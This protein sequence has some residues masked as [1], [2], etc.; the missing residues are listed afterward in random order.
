MRN[1]FSNYFL[2]KFYVFAF[3][4]KYGYW[5]LIPKAIIRYVY[6]KIVLREYQ[7]HSWHAIPIE[8]RPYG[9]HVVEYFK[10]I[11]KTDDVA[12]EVGVGIGEIINRLPACKKYGFDLEEKVILAANKVNDSKDITYQ[13]GSFNQ[14]LN[15][16]EKKLTA[17]FCLQFL[18][19]IPSQEL[20]PIFQKLINEKEIKYIV[21]DI[22]TTENEFIHD[23]EKIFGDK[24]SL[25]EEKEFIHPISEGPIINLIFKKND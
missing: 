2:G 8:L 15:I 11:L 19:S 5:Y 16:Q 7:I 10:S 17:L 9:L 23:F 1:K 18:H 24:Y 25:V 13:V 22:V 20:T 6:L 3:M 14:V 21:V 4:A 12:A